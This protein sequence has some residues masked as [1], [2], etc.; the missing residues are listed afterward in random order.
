MRALKVGESGGV[1]SGF[2]FGFGGLDL[3]LGLGL[4][5]GLGRGWDLVV[6]GL[7]GW[8][9]WGWWVGGE[10]GGSVVEYARGE[11]GAGEWCEPESEPVEEGEGEDVH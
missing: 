9:G 11:L 4:G 2:G 8:W 1:R 10:E 3:D 7:L 6:C 5:W